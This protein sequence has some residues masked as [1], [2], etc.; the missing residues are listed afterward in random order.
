MN[1]T[2][3]GYILLFTT[4]IVLISCSSKRDE[5]IPSPPPDEKVAVDLLWNQRVIKKNY[6]H[7]NSND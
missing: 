6:T 7:M 1:N 5:E 3:K 2:V 4:A